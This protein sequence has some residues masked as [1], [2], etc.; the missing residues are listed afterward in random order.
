M[1]YYDLDTRRLLCAERVEQLA[2]DAGPR[3]ERDRHRS[4]RS[5]LHNLLRPAAYRRRAQPTV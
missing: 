2:R 5:P 1:D 4:R 3:R